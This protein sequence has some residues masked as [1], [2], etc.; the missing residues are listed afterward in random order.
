MI[1]LFIR[2]GLN[3]MVSKNRKINM[4]LKLMYKWIV[5]SFILINVNVVF[6]KSIVLENK[7]YNTTV[8]YTTTDTV[9][10]RNCTFANITGDGLWCFNTKYRIQRLC[11]SRFPSYW[12]ILLCRLCSS[13]VQSNI[14]W[15]WWQWRKLPRK[16]GVDFSL[17]VQYRE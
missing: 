8:I 7:N 16:G 10:F 15:L 17:E 6:G 13:K 5:F 11:R 2:F 4:D 12:N 3:L 9:I 1:N 14:R